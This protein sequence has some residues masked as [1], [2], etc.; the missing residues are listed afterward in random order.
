MGLLGEYDFLEGVVWLNNCDHIRRIYD[1]W[2]R[3]LD[4]EGNKEKADKITLMPVMKEAG[5]RVDPILYKALERMPKGIQGKG[6]PGDEVWNAAYVGPIEDNVVLLR[7]LIALGF[8]SSALGI[9]RVRTPS[10][11]VA[12][13]LSVLSP[14]GRITL[15]EKE[16]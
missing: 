9:V 11:I 5:E 6:T 8:T 3:K 12:S 16:P 4:R 1:N 13:A 7:T 10:S 14:L 15:R 2:K